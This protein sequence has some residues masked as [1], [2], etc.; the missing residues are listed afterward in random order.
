MG[1]LNFFN[2]SGS[3][4]IMQ[5]I[6]FGDWAGRRILNYICRMYSSNKWVRKFALLFYQ[7]DNSSLIAATQRLF[8]EGYF[9]IVMCC[10]INM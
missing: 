7:E 3:L 9:D 5:A 4:L 2:N 8:M 6:I 10:F 1:D